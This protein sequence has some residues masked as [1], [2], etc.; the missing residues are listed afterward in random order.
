MVDKVEKVEKKER[1]RKPGTWG[2]GINDCPLWL[3]KKFINTAK[4]MYNDEYWPFLADLWRKAEA[5]DQIIFER[6]LNLRESEEVEEDDEVILFGGHKGINK[7]KDK[8][9]KGEQK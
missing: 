8:D 7:K 9:E 3:A 2:I 5:Y 4:G 1:R 6:D